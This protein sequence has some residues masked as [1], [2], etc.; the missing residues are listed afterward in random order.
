MN[1]CYIVNTSKVSFHG[2]FTVSETLDLTIE[3]A[4]RSAEHQEQRSMQ[5]R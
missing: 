3:Y 2:L 1:V 5:G 4:Q